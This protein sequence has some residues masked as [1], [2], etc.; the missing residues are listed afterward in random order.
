MKKT[1]FT[2]LLLSVIIPLSSFDTAPARQIKLPTN[3]EMVTALKQAL[4]NGTTKSAD[5]LSAVDGFFKNAAVKILL[6]PEAQKAEKTLRKLGLGK[7]CDNTI[8]S[9]NRAAEDAAQKAKP[10]FINSIKQMTVQDA[11]NILLGGDSSATQYFRRTTTNELTEQF[12]PVI[13]NSLS[14]VG[15][16]RLYG[17]LATQYNKIPLTFNKINPEL[18]DYVTQKAISGLFYEIALQELNIRQNLKARTT[19][20]LKKVFGYIDQK[21]N[22]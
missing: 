21:I 20:V 9:L 22:Q 2:V 13:T 1:L 4:E 18:D 11:A 15:A 12:K 10:I 8:L 3:T 6:P 17:Q 5:Q 16:T 7:L 14:K 19:P